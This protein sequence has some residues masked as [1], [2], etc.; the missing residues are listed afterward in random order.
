MIR[1]EILSIL[2]D[3]DKTVGVE[4]LDLS[5][6]NKEL[7]SIATLRVNRNVILCD[8]AVILK[9]GYVRGKNGSL[10]VKYIEEHEKSGK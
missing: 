5:T 4:C 1:I 2:K 9:T 6:G 7:L 3:K 8:N 10:P